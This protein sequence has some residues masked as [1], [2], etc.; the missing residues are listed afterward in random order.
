MDVRYDEKVKTHWCYVP[1]LVKKPIA[2]AFVDE[3]C[4]QSSAKSRDADKIRQRKETAF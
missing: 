2:F 3:T 4:Y 1:K